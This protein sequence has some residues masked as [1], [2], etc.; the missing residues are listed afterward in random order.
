MDPLFSFVI[1]IVIGSVLAS[2]VVL[3]TRHVKNVGTLHVDQ[4]NPVDSP[5]IYLSIVDI[6]YL[7]RKR[8]VRLNVETKLFEDLNC[9]SQK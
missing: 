1:G 8:Q 7:L 4:T 2:A 9:T 5:E 6:D 3:I